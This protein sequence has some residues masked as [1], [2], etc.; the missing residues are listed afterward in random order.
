MDGAD[1]Q[2]QL[3]LSYDP[4]ALR[5][6]YALERDKRLRPEG[7]KQYLKV[8]AEGE[9]GSYLAPH[10]GAP[11][12]ARD[13]ADLDVD[14]MIIGG[15]FTGLQTA[16]KLR[17]R[18]V[19][20]LLIIER[21]PDFGGNWYWNRYPG[22]AC[23]SEAYCYLPLLEE[24]GY[25]P[26]HRYTDAG[27]ICAHA[28]RIGR[29]FSLYPQTL[30]QTNVTSMVWSDEILR[31]V[32]ETDQKDTVRARFVVLA[33]GET[34]SAIKL[35]GI[36]GITEFRGKSF[37]TARWD[38]EY[39][40]G[41]VKGGMHKLADKRVAI[42]GTGC[43]AVQIIPHLGDSAKHAYVFQRTPAFVEPRNNQLTD[44][45]WAQS[46]T[47]GWQERRMRQLIANV[48]GNE[49]APPLNDSGFSDL[50]CAQREI[51]Q[52]IA[53][54]A[55]EQEIELTLKDVMELSNMEYMER[56]RA[57]IESIVRDPA[58]AEALKPYYASMCKRPTW[59]D[60]YFETFN[61]PNVT[62]VDCP[63]GVER[64]TERGLVA[65]GVEYEVDAIVYGSGY[66]VTHSSLFQIVRFPI[67]GRGGATLDELWAE[68]YRNV[69]G[70][71]INGLPNYFQLTVIGNG[72]GANYLYG[73]GKQAAHVAWIIE[74]CLNEGITSL[75]ATHDAE[76]EW[77]TT[78]DNSHTADRWAGFQRILAECTPS[79]LNSE[80]DPNDVKG[81]FANVYGGGLLGYFQI[82]QDWRDARDMSGAALT[83]L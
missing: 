2:Q 52:R 24:T 58:T 25:V 10:F 80:G 16:A 43:S 60:T 22:A 34:Y 48:E 72:L 29:H 38:Y 26:T 65:N 9:F 33:A 50:A 32:V 81:L 3:K 78:L 53:A 79:Y 83:R 74:R 15:G 7:N 44:P 19:N 39:T 21:L 66:E 68:S 82:L 77:R 59:S 76:N 51:A 27:E 35:P 4:Q 12:I 49:P 20:D 31:W 57:R 69:H 71:M 56:A 45:A 5:E 73:S 13:A 40:G 55:G 64:V 30:F 61:R 14:V 8:E 46:L 17:A 75:E 54:T 11:P 6:R 47:P 41:S 23:D 42:I 62:L 63:Q 36:P 67:V 1:L 70:M 37:H 18:G 28:Q